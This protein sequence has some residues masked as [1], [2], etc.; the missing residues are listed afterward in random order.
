MKAVFCRTKADKG[1]KIAVGDKWLY[2]VKKL[3]LKLL[4]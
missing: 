3:Y 2:T 1:F 4:L